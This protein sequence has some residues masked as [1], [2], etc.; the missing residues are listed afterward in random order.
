M[1]ALSGATVNNTT[2]FNGG[3][4]YIS[5]GASAIG[6]TVHANAIIYVS[7]GGFAD[8]TT[9]LSDGDAN[10][11]G[12]A[13]NTTLQEGGRMFVV[14]AGS[15]YHTLVNS[16]AWLNCFHG[17][18]IDNTL[19]YKGGSATIHGVGRDTTVF[20]G[21]VL[22]VEKNGRAVVTTV[23]SG[24]LLVISSGGSAEQLKL[25]NGSAAV[26]NTCI[27]TSADISSGGNVKVW[28][29]ASSAT[30]SSGG[31]M[32]V[33]G[34]TAVDLLIL[35]GGVMTMNL[36]TLTRAT[37][38]SSGTAVVEK[39]AKASETVVRGELQVL[40]GAT[41]VQNSASDL[42]VTNSG[43]LLVG[44]VV[45]GAVVNS[46]GKVTVESGGTFTSATV[47]S[48]NVVA[49]TGGK[50]IDLTLSSGGS[51]NVSS[52]G[53][54]SQTTVSSGGVV[55]GILRNTQGL[56]FS[57]GTLDLNIAKSSENDGFLVDAASYSGFKSDS[58]SCTLTVTNK[59]LNGTYYLINAASGFNKTIT[60][61]N[62]VGYQ[63]GTL[64]VGS[65][66]KELLDGVTYDLKLS[67]GDLVV[68]VTGGAIPDPIVSGITLIDERRD[69]TSGMSAIDVKVSAGG[70]LNVFSKGTASN[71]TVYDG[72]EFNVNSGGR[73]EG[74][75]IEKGGSVSILE[76]VMAENVVVNGGIFSLEQYGW[77]YHLSSGHT[78][79]SN[80][81][82]KNGGQVIVHDSACLIG[83][84]VSQGG[85]VDV[86]SDGT[87]ETGRVN[88]AEVYAFNGALVSR[89]DLESGGILNVESGGSVQHINVSAGGVLTGVL[90]EASEL[91]FYGGTLDLD[92]ST[93]APEGQFLIDE[94]SYSNID[95]FL[96]DKIYYLCTLTVD[97]TQAN[98]TYRLI[99]GAYGFDKSITVKSTGGSTLGTLTV[100][101]TAEI[102]GANY[103]LNLDGDYHLTVTVSG[104]TPPPIPGGTAKSDID[105]NGISDVMFVWTGNNYAHGY[106][107]NGTSEWQSANSNHPAEWDNLGCYDMTG[108]GKADSVLFGNVTSEAGIHG[109]YIGYYADAIDLPDGST[110]VNI[111]YLTNEENIDW[112]N[113]VGNLTGNA[114]GVNSIVWY[115]PELYAL[116]AWTDGTEN[117][118]SM[119]STF[120][121]DD[122]TLVGCGDFDGDGKDSVL[123]S[124]LNG[125]YLYAANLDGT[126]ASLGSANW[127]GW[128]VRAI[129]D[130][131]G[132]DKD[133]IVLF[134]Q[135][136]GSMV[137]C[138]DGDIDSYVSLSQLDANDWFVVGAGDY[139]GDAKDDLLVRQYSTGMLGYYVSGD[140]TQ[141]TELGRGVDMNW[142]VIA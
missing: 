83:A 2:L 69:I 66:P 37:V 26:Q 40:K 68:E 111:G 45:S 55:T 7:I 119:S 140:T 17:A 78:V 136:S 118:I 67:G 81:I 127:S 51:L 114:S 3:A 73:V 1:S 100:G 54:V 117:W 5:S 125:K 130:F 94:Q 88:G 28:G 91:T 33:E 46:K 84:Y 77:A 16:R 102:G 60:V 24:G 85:R 18:T 70:I 103:A 38:G 59:Q 129:G 6:N 106:W 63:I 49:E 131:A 92:I 124:G 98:G 34:G 97:G 108:D 101:Q 48:A 121:G 50:I 89:V 113:K 47:T 87:F 43:H 58:F 138:A 12:S 10:V 15:M 74:I 22:K 62:T 35:S 57:G 141:W 75:A 110:W 128:D 139:N 82:V 134:D 19:I 65:G 95:M 23:S 41:M 31:S 53:I 11:A 142:T 93:A 52:G 72:G 27:L 39:D 42:T 116:G 115:A 4:A 105:G 104:A 64:T 122:W 133:D 79:S 13:F 90:R 126:S 107:M 120:G 20:S 109:A 80:T 71:T 61:K 21:G 29:V 14:S 123:M 76:D 132:D 32:T 96:S 99:E 30:V 44:G 36:G 137:M 56:T 8:Q 86:L 135:K 25:R 9:V 112:K